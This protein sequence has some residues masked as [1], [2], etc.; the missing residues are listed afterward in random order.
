[1]QARRFT[2]VIADRQ[3]G[4]VRRLT[5]S[6]WPTLA[7]VA[8]LFALPVLMG[9]G[10]RWSAPDDTRRSGS[11]PKILLRAKVGRADATAG[12]PGSTR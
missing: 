7:A 10:A 4:A 12:P 1:M 5:I 9:L 6:L 8:G 3:T 11:D 2:F